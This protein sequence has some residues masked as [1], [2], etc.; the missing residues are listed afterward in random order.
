MLNL[1]KALF[2]G[3]AAVLKWFFSDR[4]VAKREKAA[5]EADIQ[6]GTDAIA[7]GDEDEVNRR[8]KKMMLKDVAILTIPAVLA[9]APG[10]A[11]RVCY[12]PQEQRAVRIEREG[13]KGWFVPDGVFALLME[14]AERWDARETK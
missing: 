4:Q 1:L 8:L 11:T 6:A 10:C 13:V 7:R 14:K 2:E 5:V 3:A 9:F 12:I